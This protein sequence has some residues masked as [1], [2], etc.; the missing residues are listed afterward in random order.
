MENISVEILPAMRGGFM[1][2]RIMEI[3]LSK[4][5]AEI[6]PFLKHCLNSSWKHL[7]I[8]TNYTSFALL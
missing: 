5:S 4:G 2:F 7:W 8:R 1:N 3:T 6:Y